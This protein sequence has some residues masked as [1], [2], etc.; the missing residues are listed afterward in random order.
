LKAETAA[1]QPLNK[2][3]EKAVAA[4]NLSTNLAMTG[5]SAAASARRQLV[6]TQTALNKSEHTLKLLLGLKATAPLELVGNI[7]SIA[8]STRQVQTA[9]ADLP[10]RR[11]DLLALQ[12]GYKSQN[13]K[14]RE[15]IL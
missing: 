14:L 6:A 1:L 7:E 9:L 13:Q 5:L 15:A 12:M 11:P 3:I 4:H 8:P 10:R 2:N